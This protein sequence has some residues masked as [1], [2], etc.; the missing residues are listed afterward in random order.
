MASLIIKLELM[1]VKFTPI[2]S[3]FI[4]LCVV[5]ETDLN[6]MDTFTSEVAGYMEYVYIYI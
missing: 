2:K 6:D 4:S 1:D 5:P 3:N